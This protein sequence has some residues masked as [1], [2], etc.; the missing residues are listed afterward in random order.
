MRFDHL[1][2]EEIVFVDQR[3]VGEPAF[4]I[5]MAF[6]N[7]RR[8]HAL[9]FFAASGANFANLSISAPDDCRCRRLIGQR[10]GRHVDHAF[11]AA[12]DEFEAVIAAA[13]TQPTSDG[14]NSI[15]VCQPMVM[16]LRL[17]PKADVTSTIGPGSR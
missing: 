7:K 9:R 17:P 12:A 2:N 14:V 16:M 3:V 11:P 15:T 5:G 4:E 1:E 13:I 8:A 6:A 10:R